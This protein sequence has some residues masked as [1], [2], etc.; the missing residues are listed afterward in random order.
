MRLRTE[1]ELRVAV[2]L[3]AMRLWGKSAAATP[4]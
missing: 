4:P 3:R 1:R 2:R